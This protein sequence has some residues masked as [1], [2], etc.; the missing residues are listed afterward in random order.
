MLDDDATWTGGRETLDY[1]L[2]SSDQGPEIG[3]A[4]A[5]RNLPDSLIA[6]GERNGNIN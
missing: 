5:L 2:A 3:I 6:S 1:A 4:S